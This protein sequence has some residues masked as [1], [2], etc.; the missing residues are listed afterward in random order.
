MYNE[1]RHTI[2]DNQLGIGP[3]KLEKSNPLHIQIANILREEIRKGKIKPGHKLLP[4]DSLAKDFDVSRA[5][6]RAALK[7][8]ENEQYLI[9]KHGSGTFV[10]EN[11]VFI[12]NAINQLRST[13][14]MAKASGLDI[15][16]E[17]I[18]LAIK[19]PDEKVRDCLGVT[20]A[21]HVV[22]LHRMGFLKGEP[23][24]YSIDT[25]PLHIAPEMSEESGFK[26]SLLAYLEDTCDIQ[27]KCA[28]ATISAVGNIP[29]P[30]SDFNKEVPALYFEQIHYDQRTTPVL[31]SI[32]YYRC[33]YF[34]FHIFRKR[35]MR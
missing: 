17:T 4:E 15:R 28:N 20:T 33:D 14:E 19:Q 1:S 8:L 35:E 30:V 13:S 6:I 31:F 3:V 16:N 2:I 34:K 11:V 23:I 29:W 10:S 12:S 18:S 7:I 22:E 27:V 32:D 9:S 5:T 25:F 24:L 21:E 26:G